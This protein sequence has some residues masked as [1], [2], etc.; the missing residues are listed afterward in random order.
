M[1]ASLWCYLEQHELGGA[2]KILHCGQRHIC[3]WSMVNNEMNCL[4]WQ[5]KDWFNKKNEK[6]PKSAQSLGLVKFQVPSPQRV[7]HVFVS[8][9][10]L[11][12]NDQFADLLLIS[13]LT[14]TKANYYY[15]A[16]HSMAVILRA[17]GCYNF[18]AFIGSSVSRPLLLDQPVSKR[19]QWTPSYIIIIVI[20]WFLSC[21]IL[22]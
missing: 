4:P 8:P 18:L 15:M 19:N 3:S 22:D 21:V 6:S 20:T 12:A 9:Y 17:F 10:S 2:K 16:G 1:V 14:I 7:K 5:I 13:R 11:N